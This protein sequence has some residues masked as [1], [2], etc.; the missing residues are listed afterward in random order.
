[1]Q[2]TSGIV[3]QAVEALSSFPGIGKRTALRLVMYLLKRPEMEVA[4]LAGALLKLK[5]ELHLWEV[6]GNVSDHK[7]C[8]VCNNSRRSEGVI[9]VVEDFSDLMAIESTAQFKGKYHVLGGLISPMDGIGPDDL[10]ISML[11]S[12]LENGM[13]EE[14]MMALSATV[15]GDTTMFYLAKK[16]KPFGVTVTCIAR[17][18]AVGGE[19]EYAD[20]V[21]LGRSIAQR[22]EYL[23]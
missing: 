11:I 18:I 22:T 17:G 4:N 6:C 8:D 20:E 16:L 7:R 2:F 12:R 15:E 1:M 10:N 21:T 14:V 19:I 23:L 3:E 13:V 9:C 5:T